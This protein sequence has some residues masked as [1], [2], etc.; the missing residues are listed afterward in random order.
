MDKLKEK[1]SDLQSQNSALHQELE[2]VCKAAVVS[3]IVWHLLQFSLSMPCFL[4]LNT[5]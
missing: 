5:L 3:V 4:M 2:R 1:A